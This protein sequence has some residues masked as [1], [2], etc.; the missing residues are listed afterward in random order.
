MQK[1]VGFFTTTLLGG[2]VFLLPLVLLTAVLGKAFQL[3]TKIAKPLAQWLNVD[4]IIGIAFVDLLAC[5]ILLLVCFLSGLSAQSTWGKT[6][7]RKIEEKIFM[8]PGYAFFKGMLTGNVGSE[9]EQATL[10]PVLVSLDD[11]SMIA[12]EVERKEGGFVS[13]Y[14]PGAPNP[15]SGSILLV[16]EDRV[17]ELNMTT[18]EVMRTVKQLGRGSTKAVNLARE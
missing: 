1:R 11:Q 5:V 17:Q 13:I 16:K 4:R 3:T 10:K 6:L 15:S 18:N 7:F 9:E 12:L 14:L 2:V 8:F